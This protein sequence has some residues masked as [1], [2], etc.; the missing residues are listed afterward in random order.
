[1]EEVRQAADAERGRALARPS[2]S[3]GGAL[4]LRARTHALAH[5]L[6]R[7]KDIFI[8]IFS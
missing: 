1:M 6:T 7:I 2:R 5:A 3:I 4:E 8:I